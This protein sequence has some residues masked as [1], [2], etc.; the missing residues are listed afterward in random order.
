MAL[1]H[2]PQPQPGVRDDVDRAG[3]LFRAFA[4]EGFQEWRSWRRLQS[5]LSTNGGSYGLVGPR[6]AGKTWLMMRAVD[7]AEDSGGVGLWFPSP[8][9]YDPQ[10]FLSSLS[11]SFAAQVERQ[12]R[13]RL[14]VPS[15]VAVVALIAAMFPVGLWLADVVPGLSI[16]EGTL[17]LPIT[18][19]AIAIALGLGLAGLV[20][21]LTRASPRGRL[22]AEARTL[23]ERIRYSTRLT[24]G[25]Q[26]GGSAGQGLF[27]ITSSQQ[28]E[29]IERPTTISSLVHDFRRLG[30]HTADVVHPA[31]VVIA[32]GVP[33]RGAR[34]GADGGRE[35]R[36]VRRRR[37][38]RP[39][40]RGAA[41]R[42]GYGGRRPLGTGVG[43]LDVAHA[44]GGG[45]ASAPD[46]APRRRVDGRWR[47]AS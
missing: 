10:A 2:P 34:D 44:I 45:V 31:R 1:T 13:S 15:P 5:V 16:A 41:R 29:L 11:D 4:A 17:L 36:H 7:E 9:E 47:R 30:R 40:R 37:Q 26:A 46:P 18:A 6:G 28:R 14:Q 33:S 39:R 25:S 42:C 3:S 19:T 23:Q 35:D 20:R 43:S 27:S 38:A 24:H 8:S 21:A 12:F 32:A 22:V